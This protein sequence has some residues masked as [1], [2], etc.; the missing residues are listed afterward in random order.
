MKH[1]IRI[2][3]VVAAVAGVVATAALGGHTAAK[4][5][6]ATKSEQFPSG[7]RIKYKQVLIPLYDWDTGKIIIGS[8]PVSCQYVHTCAPGAAGTI[9]KSQLQPFYLVVYPKG[10]TVPVECTHEPL[11]NCPDHG[12]LIAAGAEKLVPSVYGNGVKGHNHLAAPTTD[13]LFRPIGEPTLVLFKTRKA[14]NEFLKT[15]AQVLAA[16]KRGDALLYPVPQYTFI[17]LIVKRSW[18]DTATPVKAMRMKPY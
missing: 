11:E 6:H 7:E 5:N 2:L 15:R 4:A 1:R 3:V 13:P 18:Y 10:S 9:P 8:T 14:S 17:N 16:V 12:P